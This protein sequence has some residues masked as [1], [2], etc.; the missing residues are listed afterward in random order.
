MDA[1]TPQFTVV[2]VE[3]SGTRVTAV[4]P[5]ETWFTGAGAVY[6][7]ADPFVTTGTLVLTIRSEGA[8][9]TA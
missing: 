7:V 4:L 5:V 6:W 9:W 2:T 1:A 8:L 3:A